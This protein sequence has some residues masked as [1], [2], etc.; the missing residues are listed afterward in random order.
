MTMKEEFQQKVIAFVAEN[1]GLSY[2]AIAVLVGIS[3]YTLMK[4]LQKAKA[5]RRRVG[6]KSK[7][8]E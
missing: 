1:T 4:W 3:R 6:R 2:T 5:P 8:A 7:V